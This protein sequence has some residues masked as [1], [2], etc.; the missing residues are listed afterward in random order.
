M[1]SNSVE[2]RFYFFFCFIAHLL[3]VFQCI[4]L[5]YIGPK[6]IKGDQGIYGGAG[7]A[8]APG[9]S[10]VKGATGEAFFGYGPPGHRGKK[11]KI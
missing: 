2:L 4:C 8:G 9:P 11:V 5:S 3:M 6:G 1:S 10:G 7:P